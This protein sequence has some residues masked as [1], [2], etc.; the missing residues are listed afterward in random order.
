MHRP[1]CRAAEK[2]LKTTKP[3]TSFNQLKISA[4]SLK[5]LEQPA[6]SFFNNRLA[7]VVFL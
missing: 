6:N 5:Y 1:G 4:P 7:T 3:F 2:Q